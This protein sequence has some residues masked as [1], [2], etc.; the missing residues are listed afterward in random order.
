M[1]DIT[2]K[3]ALVTG[4]D[5]GIGSGIALAL[6]K[7]GA[8]IAVNY[9]THEADARS[10]CAKIQSL[11]R[12]AIA[13][14]ADVSAADQV[15][16]M[17]ESIEK[18]LGRIDI[19]INN[20][21]ITRPQPYDQVDEKSWDEILRIDLKSV[22]LVTQ[23]VLPGMHLRNWG[24]IIN[25]SSVAAYIGGLSGPHYAASKAGILGL[26]HY[27]A[28]SFTQEGITVNAIAPA[29]IETDMLGDLHNINPELIPVG[30]FGSVEEV[31]DVAVMLA[32][33]GYITGQTIHVNG[34]KYMT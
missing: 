4:G 2:G 12:Q 10:V 32:C 6:A 20:A 9:H 26:T 11:G 33:N 29:L 13:A 1:D 30:R 3:V 17:V 14:G 22:F 5:R 34:G 25:I 7:A 31:A 27:Y 21:G 8:D 15:A 23:A 28:T 24:R 18:Q 19:L 16:S